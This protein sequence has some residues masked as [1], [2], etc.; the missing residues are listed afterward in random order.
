MEKKIIN[1]D[2]I[3]KENGFLPLGIYQAG[4]TESQVLST[5]DRLVGDEEYR[6]KLFKQMTT[7]KFS[8]N[9]R[10]VIKTILDF[11]KRPGD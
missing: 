5:L 4:E 1:S 6:H 8:K 11:I 3:R 10:W 2:L 9:K 7:F